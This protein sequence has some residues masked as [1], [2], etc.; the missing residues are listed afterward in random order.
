M[1]YNIKI[2]LPLL[3][4]IL[5]CGGIV[6]SMN[7]RYNSEDHTGYVSGGNYSDDE[8][9]VSLKARGE[10]TDEVATWTY[11]ALFKDEDG[12]DYFLPYIGTIYELTV[13]NKSENEIKDWT[14]NLKMPEKCWINTGWNGDFEIHQFD[15][16]DSPRVFT[17]RDFNMT[18]SGLEYTN[19]QSC[20]LVTLDENDWF[21][22]TPTSK[23]E[24]V[25]I[26]GSDLRNDALNERTIG[27]ILYYYDKD[28]SYLADFKECRIEYHMYRSLWNYNPFRAV[29]VAFGL[30]LAGAVEFLIL[31]INTRKLI[32]Q[33]K[34]NMEIIKESMLTFANF[35]DAKDPNTKG[36]SVRVAHYSQLVARKLG[37]SEEE[38]QDVYYI[39]LLHDCGKISIPQE[40]LMKPSRL[41]E[42][43][44]TIMKSHAQKG[45]EM[46]TE[47]RSIA[48]IGEGAY[49]HHERYDGKGYPQG[50]KGEDIPLIGRIICMADAFDAMNSKRCY[51][52][53][54]P[55]SVILD[56]IKKNRGIQFD[57]KITDCFLELIDSGAVTINK[58]EVP[59]E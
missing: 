40:I 44:Y 58:K 10:G 14:F 22:Y 13:T 6:Y 57:P 41:E 35:I 48:N 54:L 20:L 12:N 24:E 51:R 56:E 2:M 16:S 55:E 34:K 18:D 39:G 31:Y 17:T 21:S 1:R 28:V 52:D 37:L 11:D 30:W 49:S 46:L 38:C 25:P 5:I 26:P 7:C 59:S 3:I 9:S 47:F 19:Y 36:H 53:M 43:E 33:N 29:C 45:Y 8:I 4:L 50:L 32:R 15:S 27:F 23:F 42:D